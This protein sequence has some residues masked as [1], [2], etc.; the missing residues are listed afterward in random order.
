MAFNRQV[1]LT[2]LVT[3]SCIIFFQ[4]ILAQDKKAE[5][6]RRVHS[7]ALNIG[8]EHSFHGIE[9]NGGSKTL[10]LPYWGFDYNFQ[11][12]RKFAVGMH[13]DYIN[14]S[15]E[16][17]KN[18]EGDGEEINRTRPLAPAVMGF[19]KPTELWSFGLGAGAEFSKE[20]SFFLNRAAVEYGVEIRNGWEVFGVFQYDFR[21][22]AY[23]TWTIGLGI[24]K[25]LGKKEKR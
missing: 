6:F 2:A 22:H 10:V 12:A 9:E 21:W 3:G 18:L 25:S 16:V 14:E 7:I 13:V 1:R 24:G 20:E 4:Q 19:Y 23:D 15:F 8:H 11:F 5:P 17:E